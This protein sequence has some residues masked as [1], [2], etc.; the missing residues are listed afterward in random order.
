MKISERIDVSYPNAIVYREVIKR[1]E[2]DG[3]RFFVSGLSKNEFK[4][5]SNDLDLFVCGDDMAYA[6]KILEELGFLEYVSAGSHRIHYIFFSDGYFYHVDLQSRY[7]VNGSDLFD[8]G[9]LNASKPNKYQVYD[10]YINTIDSFKKGRISLTEARANLDTDDIQGLPSEFTYGRCTHDTLSLA[11]LHSV[12]LPFHDIKD[13]IRVVVFK[14]IGLFRNR[15]VNVIICGID[16]SGKSTSVENISKRLSGKI[17]NYKRYDGIKAGIIWRL[18]FLVKKVI[19]V[20]KKSINVVKRPEF[21]G[22]RT[23]SLLVTALMLLYLLE[24]YSLRFFSCIKFDRAVTVTMRDRSYIDLLLYY[25]SKIVRDIL[26]Y[27]HRNDL[28]FCMHANVNTLLSR[29][30]EYPEDVLKSMLVRY[31]DV[32]KSVDAYLL[33]TTD[34]TPNDVSNIVLEKIWSKVSEY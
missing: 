18:I 16:G 23:P 10:R 33:D 22:G 2:N 27:I 28:V 20:N 5:E 4:N 3:K 21:K 11:D 29:R 19:Y 13:K 8:I 15:R 6:R 9:V 34:K 26:R 14:V 7:I 31:I 12:L 1:L 17:K 25:D 30:D 32:Y 24:Y